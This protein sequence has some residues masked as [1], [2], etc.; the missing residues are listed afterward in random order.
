MFCVPVWQPPRILTGQLAT[1]TVDQWSYISNPD[2]VKQFPEG[3]RVGVIE[4]N[5]R[6]YA[7][8]LAKIAHAFACADSGVD[9]FEPLLPG[10]IL[11]TD[12][13]DS[14]YFVGCFVRD[15][16]PEADALHRVHLET[17]ELGDGRRYLVANMRLF[18]KFGAPQ[19]HV[20]V[21]KLPGIVTLIRAE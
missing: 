7:K 11:G 18:A 9:S 8:M 16:P 17:A 3:T 15:L 6:P 20:V 14:H 13:T 10:F 19:Y 2:A 21:G 4:F 12:E 1:S 5:E